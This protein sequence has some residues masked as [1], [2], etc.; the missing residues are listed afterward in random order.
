MNQNNRLAAH[1]GCGVGEKPG[2]PRLVEE[3]VRNDVSLFLLAAVVIHVLK[4][5]ITGFPR[6]P[7]VAALAPRHPHVA[8]VALTLGQLQDEDLARLSALRAVIVVRK[9]PLF[10][11][12]VF[13]AD[14]DEG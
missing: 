11:A 7:E 3:L 13:Q 12:L 6:A 9:D 14:F 10:G 4:V 2:R 5:F 1:P 8:G